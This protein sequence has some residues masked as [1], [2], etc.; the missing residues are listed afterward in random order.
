MP[1]SDLSGKE[2]VLAYVLYNRQGKFNLLERRETAVGDER[3][4]IIVIKLFKV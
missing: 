3:G 2:R 4:V 1:L